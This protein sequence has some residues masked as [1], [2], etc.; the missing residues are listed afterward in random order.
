MPLIEGRIGGVELTKELRTRLEEQI[1]ASIRESVA[2]AFPVEL[3]F[4]QG[5]REFEIAH[6]LARKIMPGW[7]WISLTEHTW[8]IGG[9]HVDGQD[10][11]VAR[12]HV[13]VLAN[14]LYPSFRQSVAQA[15][16]KTVMQIL[17]ESG[18]KVHLAVSVIEGEVDMTL[19]NELFDDLLLGATD[20]LLTVNGVVQFLMSQVMKE[21]G[22]TREVS[23]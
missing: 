20:K 19:P 8:A 1:T 4:T 23:A 9:K 5:T 21:L 10:T 14:A 22:T 15:V 7:T 11:V 12:F 16:T 6:Q 13:L 18:K 3:G 2:E 17:G